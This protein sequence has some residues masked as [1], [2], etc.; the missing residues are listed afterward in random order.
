[1][2]E[3]ASRPPTASPE[4]FDRLYAAD[5]DPWKFA[6][7]EYERDKYAATLEALPSAHY[8]RAFEVGCSIGVLTRQLAARCA[9]ILAVDVAQAALDLAKARCEG[10][11]HVEF[12][13]MAV[14]ANWPMGRFD[15]I[16]FSEVLYYLD[17][18]GRADAARL[19]L[20]S[21]EPGGTLLLVNWH[22]PTDGFCTGDAAAEE[23]IAAC[24]PMLRPIIQ[25]RAERYRL[26]VLTA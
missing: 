26:D 5:P 17:N 8:A 22:G 13:R 20:S 16:L 24:A 3:A 25:H 12:A 14:P 7:S 9:A 19:S 18:A 10:L 15:L 4:H 21:L 11:D 6:T 2:S 23:M 1:M